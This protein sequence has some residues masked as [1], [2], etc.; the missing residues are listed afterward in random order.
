MSQVFEARPSSPLESWPG[1]A[2]LRTDAHLVRPVL[3]ITHLRTSHRRDWLKM[4]DCSLATHE[5]FATAASA[6]V[7]G[8]SRTRKLLANNPIY[9]AHRVLT[10]D[11][12]HQT[13]LDLNGSGG[14][15]SRADG[16]EA[17]SAGVS[18]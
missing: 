9:L 17:V 1:V 13:H 15:E 14:Q 10:L 5:V 4:V 8:V 11:V 12:G 6:S 3:E 18:G 7:V 2:L 16:D